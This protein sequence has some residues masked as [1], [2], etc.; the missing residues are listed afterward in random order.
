MAQSRLPDLLSEDE[1]DAVQS[2]VL[3]QKVEAVLKL[4][5]DDALTSEAAKKVTG[6]VNDSGMPHT[7]Y[8][9]S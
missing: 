4:A 1:R 7:P 6:P 9:Q 5:N 3:A 8:L 2:A